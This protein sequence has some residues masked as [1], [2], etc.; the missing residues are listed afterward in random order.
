MYSEESLS[1]AANTF[2]PQKK[3]ADILSYP[4]R[5]RAIQKRNKHTFISFK[6][7]ARSAPWLLLL[8]FKQ[9]IVQ[10]EFF[11]S[12]IRPDKWIRSTISQSERLY[13]SLATT[14]KQS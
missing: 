13:Y 6:E 1:F 10:R 9:P 12:L 11:R 3:T 14:T 8:A 5:Q 4:K 7:K 2:W